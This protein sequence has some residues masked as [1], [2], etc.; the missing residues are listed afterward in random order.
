MAIGRGVKRRT[1][2]GHAH[3]PGKNDKN[4]E[5]VEKEPFP[6]PLL[7][8]KPV[9]SPRESVYKGLRTPCTHRTTLGLHPKD[10]RA[11]RRD[12]IIRVYCCSVHRG[13]EMESP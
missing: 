8:W 1:L 9:Y 12:Q 3:L 6:P 2:S 7:G 5:A 13:K 10:V 11:Y 4:V